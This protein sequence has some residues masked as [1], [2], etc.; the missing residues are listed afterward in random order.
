MVLG[1]VVSRTTVQHVICTKLLDLDTKG[2][3]EKFDEELEKWLDD[4][5]FVDDEGDGFYINALDEANKATHGDEA[6][7]GD[8]ANTPSN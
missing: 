4:T 5:N 1:K 7:H 2:H 6:T 3:I 8:G